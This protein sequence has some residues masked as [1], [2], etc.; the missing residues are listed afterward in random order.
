MIAFCS[1]KNGNRLLSLLLQ[2]G[3]A[4]SMEGLEEALG[5]S[6]RSILYLIKKVNH[7][8]DAGAIPSIQNKKGQGYFLTDAS[9]QLLSVYDTEH[10]E[11][12]L[13]T[14]PK[15][16][17]IP[18]KDLRRDERDLLIC[19]I[20]ITQPPVSI[21]TF[22]DIFQVSRNTILQELRHLQKQ[23]DESPFFKIEVTSSGRIAAG[24]ELQQRRW[25][26]ENLPAV[27]R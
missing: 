10:D 1:Y 12:N 7:A 21:Q 6:R 23:D 22:M 4:V 20:L 8:L 5:L 18:L 16:W 17:H 11:M 3:H 26:I 2:S 14:Q 13:L 27:L 24:S 9:R 15:K 19:Y 25:I